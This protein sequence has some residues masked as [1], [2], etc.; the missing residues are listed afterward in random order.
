MA[1]RAGLPAGRRPRGLGDPARAVRRARPAGC[2]STRSRSCARRSTPRIRILPRSTR[3][4]RPTPARSGTLADARR[5]RPDKAPFGVAGRR[6]LPDQ[7]DRARLRGH[8]RMLGARRGPAR[9]ERGGVDRTHGRIL[10]RLSLAADRH[11]G[12]ERCCCWSCCWSSIAYILSP[13]AR[14]GRRCS[15]GAAPTWSG[16]WGLLQSF[17]DLLKFVLKEPVIPA[18]ANKGVFLLAPLVT[19]TAGAR[20]LGGDPGR[21]RLGDRRHQ[22]RHPL[23]LRDL[24]ARRLRRHHGRLGVELEVS[25]PGRAAL[26]G[27]DGVLRGLDRLRHH[28]RAAVRRLAEPVGDRRGAGRHVSACSAGTGCRCSRCS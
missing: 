18:G 13:T 23:H 26:G 27:A 12:A 2:P 15:C 17:A 20:R 5:R 22:C 25:V 9:P 6:L 28:H 3:S 7:P 24:V 1:N 10:D 8:G 16:P 14:S 11:R 19:C 4:R 21:R